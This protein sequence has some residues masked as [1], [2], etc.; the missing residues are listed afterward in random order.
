VIDLVVVICGFVFMIFVEFLFYGRRFFVDF[1][2]LLV[3][4]LIFDCFLL[5]LFGYFLVL[6]KLIIKTITNLTNLA[7]SI[8][9]TPYIQ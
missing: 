7:A 5:T 3:G 8:N 1:F 9:S 4:F 2:I 6:T